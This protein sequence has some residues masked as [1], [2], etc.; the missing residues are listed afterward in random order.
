M[1]FL[2]KY[3]LILCIYY[4][5]LGLIDNAKIKEINTNIVR[6]EGGVLL[7]TEK[8]I[9]GRNA[10]NNTIVA[11]SGHDHYVSILKKID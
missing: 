6:F 3:I 4:L 1:L 8:R 10:E 11:Y 2:A 5:N 9:F 7:I